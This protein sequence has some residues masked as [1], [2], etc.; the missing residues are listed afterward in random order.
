ME[1]LFV[2]SIPKLYTRLGLEYTKD[3][4][5][6][7]AVNLAKAMRRRSQADYVLVQLVDE[8]SDA[9]AD[10]NGSLIVHNVLA[11][12]HEVLQKTARV[13]G[14]LHRK[15]NQAALSALDLLRR[16]LQNKEANLCR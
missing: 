7:R 6:D 8:E 11:A 12:Q 1:A 4:Q 9:I 15:Q 14:P 13:S 10:E 2:Q 16:Y 5:A 3:L